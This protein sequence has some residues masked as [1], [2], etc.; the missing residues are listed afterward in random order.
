METWLLTSELSSL[1]HERGGGANT[2]RF[3]FFPGYCVSTCRGI[4]SGTYCFYD[5]KVL[6]GGTNVV[7]RHSCGLRQPTLGGKPPHWVRTWYQSIRFH[8]N[9]LGP[10]AATKHCRITLLYNG[11][12]VKPLAVVSR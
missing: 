1:G 4:E 8:K 10:Q 6:E 9:V 7:N 5:F 3:C 11:G 2:V 12:M